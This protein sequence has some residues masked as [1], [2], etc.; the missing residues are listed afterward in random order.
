MKPILLTWQ[1]EQRRL[2]P[3]RAAERLGALSV[4][5]PGIHAER[6]TW[7]SL[8][9]GLQVASVDADWRPVYKLARGLAKEAVPEER[10]AWRADVASDEDHGMVRYWLPLAHVLIVLSA[11]G[12]MVQCQPE[13]PLTTRSRIMAALGGFVNP[14]VLKG[15]LASV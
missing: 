9:R 13:T 14:E 11:G 4:A 12:L 3:L 8:V 6:A 2:W 1:T 5:L 7:V 10:A 15:W